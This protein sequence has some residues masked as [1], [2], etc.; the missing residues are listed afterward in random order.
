MF[1]KDV[2]IIFVWFID[3][4]DFLRKELK[5][6]RLEI[7]YVFVFIVRVVIF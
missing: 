6:I 2:L 5:S 7:D 3:L 4:V 1:M